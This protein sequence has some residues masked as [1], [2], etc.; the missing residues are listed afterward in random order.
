MIDIQMGHSQSEKAASHRRILSLAAARFR[1]LGITGL[2]LGD[3]MKEAGLT[4]GAFYRHFESRE[5]L[6]TE[7]VAFALARGR[8]RIGVQPRPET[9][10]TAEQLIDAYLDEAHRDAPGEGCAVAA[11][12]TDAARSDAQ[13]RSE[14]TRQVKRNIQAMSAL[15][16]ASHE[17]LKR[18]HAILV[19]CALVG[20]LALARAVNDRRLS[21]EILR[22]VKAELRALLGVPH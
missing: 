1:E 17:P 15:P 5:A 2:S 14:Y 12:V 18:R 21:A 11:L 22:T 19:W 9:G 6:V 7:A 20:A 10:L 4:H 8:E 3:L 13:T 16:S